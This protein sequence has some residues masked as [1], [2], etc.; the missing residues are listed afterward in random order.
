M[1]DCLHVLILEDNS[2]DAELVMYELR[3]AGLN[4]DCKIVATESDYVACLE[5]APDLIIADYSLPQLN[6]LQA[7]YLLQKR[8]LDI[9]FIIVTGAVGEEVVVECM[10]QGATDYLLKDRLARLGS[11]V[12]QSLEQKAT[13]EERRSAGELL[14]DS[15]ERYRMLVE[16]SSDAIFLLSDERS[17]ISCNHAFCKL[18]GYDKHDVLGKSIRIIHPSGEDYREF[19][20]KVYPGPGKRVDWVYIHKTGASIPVECVIS[21]IRDDQGETKGYV[22]IAR[23]ITER[24]HAD[25]ELKRYQEHLEELVEERANDL[26]IANEQLKR[27]IAERKKAEETAM[28]LAYHD[29]LTQLP[30]RLLFNDRLSMEI[31]HA[32]RYQKKVGVM[33]LDLDGFKYVNDRLGHNMG[34]MLLQAVAKHLEGIL[35]RVDTVARMGGDEFIVVL[36]GLNQNTDASIVA[37]NIINLFK[38]PF[39]IDGNNISITTSI[40]I[41]IYPEDG[42]DVI[43]LVKNA[44]FAMYRAKQLG[45]NTYKWYSKTEV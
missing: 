2:C 42:D 31:I 43:T 20:E 4:T 34:D 28:H 7:L 26:R 10:K 15:E 5:S 35:R 45:K 30:N 12:K 29:A 1:A 24:K 16:S 11:A 44:D 6:A 41:A 39:C 33:M 27:E 32:N 14:R 40:G 18:F 13:R 36:S 22:C 19:I 21:R 9:P 38:T 25:E 17:I 8:A 3:K 23:D 37:K